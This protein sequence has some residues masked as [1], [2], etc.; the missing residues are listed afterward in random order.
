MNRENTIEF[1]INKLNEVE[2]LVADAL[3][4]ASK[5]ISEISDKISD[6]TADK[7][8]STYLTLIDKI[9]TELT[10]QIN[11]LVYVASNNPSSANIGSN[12]TKVIE[13]NELSSLSAQV[14][15]RLDHVS[16]ICKNA[17]EQ[18]SLANE[19]EDMVS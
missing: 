14:A 10:L 18:V 17:K 4:Q 3:T 9:E 19:S 7:N 15:A 11:H 13:Y 8:L 5:C 12:F 6:K 1:R 2:K 16:N